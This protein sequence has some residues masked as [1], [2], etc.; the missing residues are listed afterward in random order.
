MGTYSL[1]IYYVLT[2]CYEPCKM[3]ILKV[4][5]TFL[6]LPSKSSQLNLELTENSTEPIKCF[7]EVCTYFHGG[8]MKE[9]P[10]T[11][12]FTHFGGF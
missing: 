11:D 10:K 9:W 1:S 5:T 4:W 7:M 3:L 6:F 12:Q 8:L 2:M